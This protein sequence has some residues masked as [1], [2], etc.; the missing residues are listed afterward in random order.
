MRMSRLMGRTLKE[1]PRDAELPSHR[2]LLRAGFVRKYSSGVYGLLPLAFRSIQKIENI[3]REEMDAIDGQEV[4]MPCLMTKELWDESGRYSE[5][6]QAMFRFP[7][8]AGQPMLLGMTHEEAVVALSRTEASSY[9]Q[10]PFMLYQIQTKFRDEPRPRGGLVRLREFTMKDA[11]SFHTSEGDLKAYY[12]V[13]HHAYER[14]FTRAG[15]ENFVSVLS[16]NGMFGGK[17]SHEFMAL[18]EYG[19]DTLIT[20]S[21]C[22][23]KANQEIAETRLVSVRHEEKPL[24]EVETGEISSIE[25]LAQFLEIKPQDTCKAVL[26]QTSDKKPIVVFVRGDREV[27]LP[28]L[29]SLLQEAVAPAEDEVLRSCGAFPGCTGPIGLDLSKATVIIDHSAISLSNTVIGSNRAGVHLKNF[30]F[31]RDFL[32]HLTDAERDL[33]QTADVVK[34]QAGDLCPECNSAL[35]ESRG[36]EIGNIFHLGDRY[37]HSMNFTYLNQ[38]GKPMNPTMGCYGLGV[39]RLLAALIEEHHDERGMKLPLPVAPYQ[40]HLIGINYEKDESVK[41]ECDKIYQ[42]LWKKGIEV[43]LDDRPIKAGPQFADADLIGLPIRLTISKKTLAEES[44]EF[45][46][47]DGREELKLLGLGVAIS[48]IRQAITKELDN[49]LAMAASLEG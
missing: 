38:D 18:S 1:T 4:R 37:S 13:V 3:V 16:D 33:I 10:F 14:I 20:C 31:K 15:C 27:V 48:T 45:R 9:K 25:K 24:S 49:Y 47:R 17:F 46:Y 42:E 30:S 23:Y 40:V 43:L 41:R 29:V 8:R 26:F 7:D 28:K 35:K 19:E 39:N 11:Y 32:A 22:D 21:E 34:T 36:I 44:L 2:L 12:K 6:D 5:I